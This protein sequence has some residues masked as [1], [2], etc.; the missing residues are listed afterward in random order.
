[1][2][3]DRIQAQALEAIGNKANAAVEIS[4]G[5]GKTVLGL[6]HMVKNYSDVASFLVV[7]PRTKI[8]TSWEDDAQ[9]FDLEYLLSHITFSTYLSL[10]K[11]NPSDYDVIYLDECHSLKESHSDWLKEFEETGGKIIGLTGTYPV[12]K[13]TEKGKMC[14]KFCPVVYQY[15]TDDAVEDLILNDYRIVIHKLTLDNTQTMPV[16]TKDGRQFYTSEVKT[17]HY[18]NTRINVAN[19]PKAMQMARIGRMKA[20]QKMP[21]KLAYAKKLFELQSNKTIVFANTKDQADSLCEYRVHSSIGKKKAAEVLENF[22]LG[23]IN[24]ISAVDQLS[25]GVT[26]PNLKVGIIMHAYANNRKAS[27][28][29]GR[30]LRLNPDDVATVHILCYIDTVDND[31]VEEAL[32]SF[33]QSKIYYFQPDSN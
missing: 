21:S 32:S 17:Y 13:H 4:M 6:K 27:Q 31:W 18:W 29:I 20:L 3:K 22:K 1:M 2:T 33:D 25:E 26:I 30:L 23:E 11:H 9:G 7:A 8:F 10:T 19:N 28:K 15:K 24:K 16:K 5:V 14:N 12:K